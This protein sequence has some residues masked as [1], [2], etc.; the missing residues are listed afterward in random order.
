MEQKDY[1]RIATLETQL[2]ALS[3]G[4]ERI[5]TKLDAYSAN[6]LTR[7]EADIR[8]KHFEEELKE[9]KENKRANI[10]LFVSI[11]AVAVTFIFSLLNYLRQ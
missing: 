7:N 5:E 9:V 11:A 10:S 6:F 3:K 4:L 2:V 8:F 1:E